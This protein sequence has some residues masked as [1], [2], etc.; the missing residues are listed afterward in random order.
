ML[1]KFV[2]GVIL[3]ICFYMVGNT[4]EPTASAESSIH[5]A[6]LTKKM[7]THPS[8]ES[9]A[10]TEPLTA[11]EEKPTEVDEKL[12]NSSVPIQPQISTPQKTNE[13]IIWERLI[14]E[15]FTREQTAGIMGN[16]Q[17]E[18][19]FKTSD[20]PGGLGIAQ[21][22]GNRRANL[23]ARGNYEDLNVQ[24]DYLMAELRGSEISAYN[25]ITSNNSLEFAIEA[26]QNKFERCN[27]QYCMYAQ[28]VQYARDILS[29]N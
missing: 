22:T 9:E 2:G 6:D 13:R 19:G 17:Q 15:G 11:S 3:A 25:S 14:A 28:R 10:H 16:L 27:P 1:L 8:S 5:G 24:L 29:R 12:V 18:H 21:W 20:V 4:P 26:F 7:S 23:M